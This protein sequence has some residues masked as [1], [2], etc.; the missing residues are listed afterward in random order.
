MYNYRALLPHRCTHT[1]GSIG[2]LPPVYT[3]VALYPDKVI[4]Y[5]VGAVAYMEA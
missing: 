3:N 1:L 2:R 4:C 5:S